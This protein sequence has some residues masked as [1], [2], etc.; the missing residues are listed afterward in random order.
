MNSKVLIVF[1]VEILESDYIVLQQ[2]NKYVIYRLG[3]SR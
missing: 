1:F 2:K 3:R